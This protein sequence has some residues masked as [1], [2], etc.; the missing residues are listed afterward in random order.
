MEDGGTELQWYYV[1]GST[2]VNIYIIVVAAVIIVVL[3][4]VIL[5]LLKRRRSGSGILQYFDNYPCKIWKYDL[6]KLINFYFVAGTGWEWI[7]DR[8]YT[9]EDFSEEKD[10]NLTITEKVTE[11]LVGLLCPHRQMI[12]LWCACHR[13]AESCFR[14]YWPW[15]LDHPSIIHIW[16][17][18]LFSAGS[19]HIYHRV[20]SVSNVK[21]TSLPG[22]HP[23]AVSPRL[24]PWS[25]TL[26][27]VAL[28]HSSQYPHFLLFPKPPPLRK[29]HSALSF[30]PSDSLRLQHRSPPQC[31]ISNLVL[32]ECK[33]SYIELLQDWI[34]AHWSR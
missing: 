8:I 22:T 7:S 23:P 14:H 15:N 19:S 25:S 3:V 24:C 29:W 17:P 32:D 10:N 31:S 34:S 13:S 2:S 28:H 30:L 4:V 6:C 9:D 5:L 18:W 11:L 26:R 12:V 21:P 1:A 16:Y 33:S 20:A 27:H